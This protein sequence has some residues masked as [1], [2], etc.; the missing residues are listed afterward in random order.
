MMLAL[1]AKI[2]WLAR[3]DSLTTEP[4]A[5]VSVL[6]ASKTVL[7]PCLSMSSAVMT[8]TGAGPSTSARLMRE[9][10]TVT[11]SSVLACPLAEVCF[12]S[13]F[14]PVAAVS[15]SVAAC[16]ANNGPATPAINASNSAWHRTFG[17]GRSERIFIRSPHVVLSE[18]GGCPAP[19]K[20]YAPFLTLVS[21]VRPL[22][23]IDGPMWCGNSHNAARHRR[24]RREGRAGSRRGNERRFRPCS[25]WGRGRRAT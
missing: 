8:V 16:W 24:A 5:W 18:C 12:P 3:V 20:V 6:R 23:G 14:S 22:L 13:S 7:K 19:W 4:L 1:G 9:P 11:C 25:A 17:R 15:S 10:V 21:D 2:D